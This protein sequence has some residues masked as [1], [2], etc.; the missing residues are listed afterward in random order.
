VLGPPAAEVGIPDRQLADQLGELGVAGVAP[1]VQ[2]QRGDG[3]T[4]AHLPVRVQLAGA[5]VQEHV[6]GHVALALR[7]RVE[8]GEQCAGHAVAGQ[9]VPA[10]ADDHGRD[11]GQRFQHPVQAGPH[12]LRRHR[13]AS[14]ASGPGQGKEVV[15]L[16]IGQAQRPANGVQHGIGRVEAAAALQA[17]VVVHAHPGELGDLLPAQARHAAG[18]RLRGQAGLF[19]GDPGPAGAQEL[20]EFRIAPSAGRWPAHGVQG[21]TGWVARCGRR[22]VLLGPRLAG[23]RVRAGLSRVPERARIGAWLRKGDKEDAR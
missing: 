8:V 14:C 19:G 23:P 12:P 21:R 10:A 3:A 18:T 11:V 2:V 9:D 17:D 22:G 15:A 5:L 1:G 16:R 4:G 6:A 7:Q 13:A 20:P